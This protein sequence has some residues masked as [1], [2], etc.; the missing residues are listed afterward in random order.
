MK[1]R[2]LKEFRPLILPGSL[3]AACAML[4]LFESLFLEPLF[5]NQ[6]HHNIQEM[7]GM[8]LGVFPIGI[9]LLAAISFGSEFQQRTFVLL[10]SQ[11]S[12]RFRIWRDKLVTAAVVIGAL[13]LLQY[14]TISATDYFSQSD[15]PPRPILFIFIL[16]IVCSTPFWT[17]MARSTIGGV[18]FTAM[19]IFLVSSGTGFI[20]DKLFFL[21][22]NVP[23]G[24]FFQAKLNSFYATIGTVGVLYSFIFLWLGWRKFSRMELRDVLGGDDV[25]LPR[26]FPGARALANLLRCR[27]QNALGNLIRKELRL[28]KTC[29]LI[30]IIFTICWLLTL[31]LLFLQPSRHELC[32]A[33]FNVLTAFYI[34]LIALLAGCIS[35]GEE[36]TLGLNAW[37]M[38]LPPSTVRQWSIKL[39]IGFAAILL[40]GVLLPYLLALLA[41]V[42]IKVGVVELIIKEKNAWAFLFPLTAVLILSFWAATLTGNTIRAALMTVSFIVALIIL[43]N[44]GEWVVDVSGGLETVLLR[45]LSLS[46]GWG[47]YAFKGIARLHEYFPLFLG[48]IILVPLWQSLRFFRRGQS[49]ELKLTKEPLTLLLILFA[50]VLWSIDFRT[51][52]ANSDRALTASIEHSLRSLHY[53]ESKL[54]ALGEKRRYTLQELDADNSLPPEIRSWMKDAVIL[55]HHDYND[56]ALST[57]TYYMIHA[58]FKRGGMGIAMDPLHPKVGMKKKI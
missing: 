34:P 20:F 35:I 6:S 27:P 54:P 2:L 21:D 18:A 22:G 19:G 15:V 16:A 57:D 48:A 44:V 33:F 45:R 12:D 14:L 32:E 49:Q 30:A 13:S 37:H 29:F 9:V 10:L 28:Q 55:I 46:N 8:I 51:S 5:Q 4:A 24:V 23:I 11:P 1:A 50:T 42:K 7:I 36:K 17:L 38:T 39:F 26:N 47:P 52:V 53:E 58:I 41:S 25:S 43:T 31:A 56:R 3:I 40:L